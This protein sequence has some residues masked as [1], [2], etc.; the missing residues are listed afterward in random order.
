MMRLC[1]AFAA[2]LLVSV[3]PADSARADGHVYLLRGL[4]NVFSIGMD[5]LAHK[6]QER[7]VS[8]SVHAY[9]EFEAL[10]AQA[11]SLHQ[12]GKGPIIIVGHSYGADA[13][14]S[15][16]ARMKA[17]GTPVALLVLFGPTFHLPIPSNVSQVVNYYQSQSRDSLW[18]GQAVKGP[19]F[20]GSI[21]NVNLDKDPSVTHFNIEKIDRLHAETIDRIVALTNRSRTAAKPARR[22]APH[23]ATVETSAR[24]GAY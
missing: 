12:S 16:A 4:F 10:A 14:A 8:T 22:A 7:G 5:V 6:L 17:R 9:I 15:M 2:W 19:G 13:A 18:H 11:A 21:V 24:G 23:P 20:L 3:Y 1:L